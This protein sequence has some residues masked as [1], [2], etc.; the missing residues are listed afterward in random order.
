M[1]GM[2]LP[3]Y[4]GDSTSDGAW[5]E[6]VRQVHDLSGNVSEM[7]W[8]PMRRNWG[9]LRVCLMGGAPA[10]DADFA[11]ADR[12]AWCSAAVGRDTVGFR[13]ARNK[14]EVAR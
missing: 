5:G 9:S 13:F 6:G 8:P 10:L 14:L 2:V 12:Q 3:M 11:R 1:F 7:A 4:F